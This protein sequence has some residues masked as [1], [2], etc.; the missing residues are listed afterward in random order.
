MKRVISFAPIEKLPQLMIAFGLFVIDS[1]LPECC[2]T[3]VPLTTT[4]FVGFAT[5]IP[6]AKHDA[7]ASAVAVRLNKRT[8]L[9]PTLQ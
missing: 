7:T 1:R 2:I 4:G 5:A 8:R 9:S 3:A 6:D